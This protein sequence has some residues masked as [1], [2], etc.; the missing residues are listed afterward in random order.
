M[1]L[2]SP[3]FKDYLKPVTWEAAPASLRAFRRDSYGLFQVIA[4][5]GDTGLFTGYFEPELRASRTKSLRFCYPIYAPPSDLVALPDAASHGQ[6]GKTAYG[7]IIGGKLVPHVTRREVDE[8]AL[9]GLGLELFY[10]EDP[11]DLFFMHVQ[12][13]ACLT[14]EDGEKIHIGFAGKSG[15]AYTSIGK[16]MKERGLLTSPITMQ[17]IKDYL[18]AHPEERDE[19][20]QQNASYI[21]FKTLPLGGPMGASGEVLKAEESLAIDD[22]IWP[23]GLEVII[24]TQDPLNPQKPW[25]KRLRTADTGSAIRGVIRGDI[26][27]GSGTEAAKKAGPM[28]YKG[29]MWMLLPTK[30]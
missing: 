29:R 15:H 6:V 9:Q 2:T 25:V 13:S 20:L 8:G 26:Y 18:R 27:F 22:T 21:F 3:S 23:Y 4:P 10:A 14:L 28:Q 12:G 11:V 1:P 17:S 30:E 19:I 7:K 5:E 16:I 24:E